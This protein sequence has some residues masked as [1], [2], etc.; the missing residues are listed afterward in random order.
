M[1]C[2]STRVLIFWASVV[3]PWRIITAIH[4]RDPEKDLHMKDQEKAATWKREGDL[5]DNRAR[6][7]QGRRHYPHLP[8]LVPR[9]AELLPASQAK[10]LNIHSDRILLQAGI[11]P[12]KENTRMLRVA[13]TVVIF[14]PVLTV[15]NLPVTMSWIEGKTVWKMPSNK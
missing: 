8:H 7:I 15:G 2:P 12:V 9:E 11:R 14:S 6:N 10:V 3:E 1:D 4:T 13:P 5:G